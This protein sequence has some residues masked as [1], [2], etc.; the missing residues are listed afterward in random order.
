MTLKEFQAALEVAFEQTQRPVF[1]EALNV[2]NN[3]RSNFDLQ[4]LINGLRGLGE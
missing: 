4:C 3:M 2:T 1:Q